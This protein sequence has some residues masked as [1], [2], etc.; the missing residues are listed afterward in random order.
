M[1]ALNGLEL[2]P[3]KVEYLKYIFEKDDAVKT[4]DIASRF[5]VDPSTITKTLNELAESGLI[6]HTPYYGVRP[7]NSGRQYA[8][9]LIKRHRILSLMLTHFGISPEQACIEVSRFES[10]VSKD[11]IDRICNSMGHPNKGICGDIT[12]DDGCLEL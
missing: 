4:N 3:R 1:E 12:H 11:A 6:I 2:S 5:K 10:H 8:E 7:S 9:F